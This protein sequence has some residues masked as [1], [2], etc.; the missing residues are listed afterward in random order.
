M[1][2]IQDSMGN[3]LNNLLMLKFETDKNKT[4]NPDSVNKLDSLIHDTSR[5]LS[6]LNSLKEVR[7]K[8]W[9][10]IP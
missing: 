3:F 5:R 7:E 4:L 6:E 8:N 10:V 2:T 1:R 9:R